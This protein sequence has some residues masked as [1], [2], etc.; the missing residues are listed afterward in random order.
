MFLKVL[1][2]AAA[3]GWPATF[4][5]C[6]ACREARRR[7]GKNIR[8]RTTYQIGDTVHVDWGPDSYNSMISFGLDYSPLRHLFITHAHQ[9]HWCPEELAWRRRGFSQI[10]EGSHL[11][12]YGNSHVAEGLLK[13]NPDLEAIAAEFRAVKPYEPIELGP[14]FT[15][16]GFTASHASEDE[17]ALNYLF[18][19]QGRGLVIGN[20]TGW[21]IP[22]S[23][24][25]LQGFS[26]SLVVMDCTSGPL[27][28]GP[29]DQ[30]TSWVGTHHLNC[31]WVVEVRDELARRGALTADHTFIANHFSHNGGWLHEQLEDFFTPH[32]IL[33]GYDG[34]EIDL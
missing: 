8:R 21:W 18:M 25:F 9:D 30:S 7:G 16:Y 11:A 33:V 22:E 14:D 20:D 31:E 23:W 32:N 10:P 24:D 4:C 34:L 15:A 1:G 2:S 3:E 5:D 12:V 28:T 13:E 19:Y 26:L 17:L 27:G 29:R 6:E